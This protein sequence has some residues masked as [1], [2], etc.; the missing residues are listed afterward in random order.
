MPRTRAALDAIHEAVP[1]L[2]DHPQETIEAFKVLATLNASFVNRRTQ[3][4][5]A[6]LY[7]VAW[8][9]ATRCYQVTVQVASMGPDRRPEV[10]SYTAARQMIR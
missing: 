1:S 8:P 3:I 6:A 5:N 2:P 4:S 9:R 10:D 7:H